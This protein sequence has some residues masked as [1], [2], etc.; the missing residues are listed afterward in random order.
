MRSGLLPSRWQRSRADAP[1]RDSLYQL[2]PSLT[3]Q[4][5]QPLRLDVFQGR[6]VVVS[7]FFAS[8]TQI[9]PML[10]SDIKRFEAALTAEERARLG[11]VLVSFDAER[12]GPAAFAELIARHGLD[13]AR[14]RLA[15]APADDVRLLAAALGIRFTKQPDGGFV[16]SAVITLLDAQGQVAGRTEGVLQPVAPLVDALRRPQPEGGPR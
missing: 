13:A 7:M 3:D 1:T 12:D 16:H 8:C 4:Q 15:T 14:W 10:I 9:C 2:A 6:P 5:G 11:V